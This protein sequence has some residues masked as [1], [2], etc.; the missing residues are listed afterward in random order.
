MNIKIAGET[1]EIAVD[2]LTS[3]INTRMV[4]SLDTG[5][6]KVSTSID[7]GLN[8]LSVNLLS[9]L[10]VLEKELKTTGSSVSSKIQTRRI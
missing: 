8:L 2:L 3:S 9:S 10:V 7:P 5:N 6:T 4:T 1:S